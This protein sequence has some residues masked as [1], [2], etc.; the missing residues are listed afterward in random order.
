MRK[1]FEANFKFKIAMCAPSIHPELFSNP[2]QK[3]LLFI[4]ERCV[5]VHVLNLL[6]LIGA[7]QRD[8]NPAPEFSKRKGTRESLA[9]WG[10]FRFARVPQEQPKVTRP[11]RRLPPIKGSR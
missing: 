6:F 8:S 11:F 2:R 7:P 3:V 5:W 1:Q 9:A 4:N 10:A